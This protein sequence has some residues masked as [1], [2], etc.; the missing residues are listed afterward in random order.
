MTLAWGLLVLNVLTFAPDV[1]ILHIP[2]SLGK[3]ITQGS[4]TAALFIILTVNHKLIIRPNFFLC[5]VSVLAID[6]VITVFKAQHLVGT[7]YRTFRLVEFVVVLWLFTPFWAAR[8]LLLVRLHLKVMGLVIASVIV[9][10][11]LPWVG[12]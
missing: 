3:V 7:A 1:S 9:G 12:Y 6:T 10:Y 11:P 2:S 4:L 8:D 5:L